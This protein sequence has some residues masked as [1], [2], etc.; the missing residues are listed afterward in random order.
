[1]KRDMDKY[2]HEMERLEKLQRQ[3]EARL[4]Q[5]QERMNKRFEQIRENLSKKYGEPSTSQQRIIDAALDLLDR[6]GLNDLSLRKLASD[7]D[8]KAS[9]LYWHFKSKEDLIDYMA[10]AILQTEFKDLSVR[11]D[12]EPWQ[13][14]IIG[15]SQKLRKAMLSR[16]DGARIVAGAHPFPAVTILNITEVTLK[17][18]VSAGLSF[19]KADLVATIIVNFTY[20]YVIEEQDS[21]TPEEIEENDFSFMAER[22]PMVHELIERR[23]QGFK[24]GNDEFESCLHLIVDSTD[25]K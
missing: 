15:V 14:W 16:R 4:S 20:G 5:Q 23:I 8:L 2:A 22:F 1:M 17:S 24:M 25:K 7:L 10:E 18:L 13:D 12:D 6:E 3:S 21:P 19:E 11:P 9:A